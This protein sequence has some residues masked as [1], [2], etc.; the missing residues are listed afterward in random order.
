MNSGGPYFISNS[1]V[2]N[3]VVIKSAYILRI[4]HGS[5]VDPAGNG[6]SEFKKA[7]GCRIRPIL[8]NI[9]GEVKW[10]EKI[11]II[12]INITFGTGL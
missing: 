6:M 11:K 8:I 4:H 12:N 2:V 3:G 10:Y 9:Y 5:D 1:S 7:Y